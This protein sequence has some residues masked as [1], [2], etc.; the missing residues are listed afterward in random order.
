M[1]LPLDCFAVVGLADDVASAVVAVVGSVAVAY[2]VEDSAD[3]ASVVAAAD[4]FD[5]G[6][7]VFDFLDGGACAEAEL[8]SLAVGGGFV[9]QHT[10]GAVV[11]GVVIGAEGGVG[12]GDEAVVVVVEEG[13]GGVAV[14]EFD[15]A[16]A[17]GVEGVGGESARVAGDGYA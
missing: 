11:V 4:V 13:A 5:G 17:V 3:S 15:D 1:A 12:E 9:S 6:G 10:A 7:G 2:G 14:F 16:V 8:G